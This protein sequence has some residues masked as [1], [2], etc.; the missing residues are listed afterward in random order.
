MIGRPT[1]ISDSLLDVN[2]AIEEAK[3][4]EIELRRAANSGET[5][6]RLETMLAEPLSRLDLALRFIRSALR[7]H[8]R[9]DKGEK[10]I[11]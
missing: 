1:R 6:F 2:L 9:S 5:G 10:A 8:G 7:R 11:K 3:R 4:A